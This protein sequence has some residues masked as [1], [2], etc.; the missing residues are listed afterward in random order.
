MLEAPIQADNLL[1]EKAVRVDDATGDLILEGYASTW[2]QDRQGEAFIPGGFREAIKSFLAG[3]A[4][5]LYQHK[6][7]AQLGTVETLEERE[8]GLWMRAR[9]PEPPASAPLRHQWELAKRGYL[10]GAS[11]RGLMRKIGNKLTMKDMYEISLTPTPVNAG[12][13]LAV[14]QKALDGE[15]EAPPPP[16]D[17]EAVQMWFAD[18]LD[19]AQR[20]FDEV[21]E[22]L[23]KLEAAVPKVE[24]EGEK[25][26][27]AEQRKKYGMANGEF[28]IWHCGNGPGG[29]GAAKSDLGRTKLDKAAVQAHIARRAKALG[30]PDKAKTND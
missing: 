19:T 2:E 15:A 29:V 9:L 25:A 28:P 11:V 13:L 18:Q 8:K 26:I 10:R 23:A 6:D 4:P 3:S 27:T 16:E 7:G 1:G 14:A 21:A 30:C 12:G 24:T 22:G 20:R 5:L 17:V